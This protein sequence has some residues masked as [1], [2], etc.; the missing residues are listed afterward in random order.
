M[1]SPQTTSVGSAE[2][3][4][5]YVEQP[6]MGAFQRLIGTLI[7][8]GETF[9]DI[10]RKPDFLLPLLLA[11]VVSLA[12]NFVILKRLNPD[13]EKITRQ[14]V[15]QQ[16]AKNNKTISDLSP[17]EREAVE[18]QV[19]MGAKISPYVGY[20]ISILSP[21][22]IGLFALL[23]WAGTMLISGQSTFKKVFSVTSYIY[24]VVL[25]TIQMALNVL[26]A[27]LR[28]PEDIDLLKGSIAVTNPGMM[29]PAGSNAI[30]EALLT[31]LDIFSIWFIVLM[32]IGLAKVCKKTSTGKAATVVVGLWA[33]WVVLA[34]AWRAII[35]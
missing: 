2:E 27:F 4:I 12:G 34:V 16:L 21:L 14:A 19:K 9:Q 11:I 32:S 13:Y 7:S 10:N 25:V 22:V 28:N 15:E 23:F 33:I 30:V 31:R 3:K 1:S 17:Q 6:Q 20:V 26:V 35:G 18:A 24:A 5:S 29:L 8:P